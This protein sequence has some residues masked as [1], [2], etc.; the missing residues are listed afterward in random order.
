MANWWHEEPMR[1]V[2]TNL[3]QIDAARD[4]REIIGEVKDFGGNAVLFSVGGIVSFYP[5][6]LEFQTPIPGLEGDFVS[7]AREEAS[8]QGVR[9]I[10][11]LDLSKCH[12]HVFDSHP[13]WFYKRVDGKPI[14]Y[15][16]VNSTCINGGYY[17]E[18]CFEIMKEVIDRYDDGQN[19]SRDRCI[20]SSKS[21]KSSPDLFGFDDFDD[22]VDIIMQ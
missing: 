8:S 17:Q 12:K 7:E 1:L 3:R 9:F 10:A 6:E 22:L 20:N 14:I 2:Q 5:S 11:R 21:S 19:P 4:P 18:Y 16:G 13:E 15:N